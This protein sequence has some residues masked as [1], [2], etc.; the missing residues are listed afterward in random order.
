MPAMALP[1]PTMP[2][3]DML[4]VVREAVYLYKDYP[5]AF[6]R[7]RRRAMES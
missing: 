2:A 3:A 4:Y 1:S 5:D 6:G 7:L